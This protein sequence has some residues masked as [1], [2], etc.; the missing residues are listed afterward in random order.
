[1]TG[2]IEGEFDRPNLADLGIDPATV[3]WDRAHI[4][5]GISDVRA[6][7]EQNMLTWNGA[8]RPFLPGTNG[9][10]DEARGSTRWSP[11]VRLIRVSS[12]PSHCH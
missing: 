8:Q 1:L 7:R 9:F 12:F 4:A 3:A 5:V 11:S 10:V 6:I 2:S